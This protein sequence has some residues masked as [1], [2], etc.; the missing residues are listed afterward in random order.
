MK[1]ETTAVTDEEFKAAGAKLFTWFS[2]LI[3]LGLIQITFDIDSRSR[4]VK[5][6][7]PHIDVSKFPGYAGVEGK[8]YFDG[9]LEET[10]LFTDFAVDLVNA[11]HPPKSSTNQMQQSADG[12]LLG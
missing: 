7:V 1:V 3:R 8:G 11:C 2:N 6:R 12:S 4:E 5:V 9:E 10:Y